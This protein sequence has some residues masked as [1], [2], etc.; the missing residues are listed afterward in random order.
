M[1]NRELDK[2]FRTK[3]RE[4]GGELFIQAVNERE[5]LTEYLVI[6]PG[7]CIGFI[8]LGTEEKVSRET[9]NKIHDLR[10][11]GCAAGRIVEEKHINDAMCYVMSRAYR[12]PDW[13]RFIA[14]NG[15]KGEEN[16]I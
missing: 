7:G 9:L 5:N 2:K 4:L 15:K 11:L 1:D 14:E 6:L 10:R 16:G 12:D 8:F 13:Y 3:V